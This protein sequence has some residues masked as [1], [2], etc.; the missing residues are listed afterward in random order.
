[1]PLEHRLCTD[2]V[3]ILGLVIWTVELG[4]LL[5]IL[6]GN[7]SGALFTWLM[8]PWL[9]VNH[10]LVTSK[11]TCTLNQGYQSRGITPL[12]CHCATSRGVVTMWSALALHFCGVACCGCYWCEGCL[13][14]PHFF[15]SILP[16]LTH[17]SSILPSLTKQIS[18]LFFLYRI[19]CLIYPHW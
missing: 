13:C 19:K 12:S 14:L 6:E 15:L 18:N 11:Y 9:V 17:H 5:I 7:H 1:M 2:L 10:P 4:S 3:I 8:I 16:S